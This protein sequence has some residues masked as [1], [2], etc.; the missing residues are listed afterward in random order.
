ML[1]TVKKQIEESVE[2]K[3]D[4]YYKDFIGTPCYINQ[5]GTL[6]MVRPGMVSVWEKSESSHYASQVHDI[7]AKGTP[8]T[9]AEFETAYRAALE[10]IRAAV[11]VVVINS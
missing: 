4:A 6:I 5:V 8:C 1:L 10:T 2:V 3:T 9:R 11:N 7:V